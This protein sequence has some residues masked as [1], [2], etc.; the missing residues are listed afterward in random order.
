MININFRKILKYDPTFAG[1]YSKYDGYQ[2]IG[3]QEIDPEIEKNQE[4]EIQIPENLLFPVFSSSLKRGIQTTQ[5]YFDVNYITALD[6][7]KEVKFDLRNLLTHHEYEKFG[8]NLVRERFI[9]AFINDSL[10][11]K[12]EDIKKRI[13][14]LQNLFSNLVE[15]N[16]LVIS[17]SFFMKIFDTYILNKNIFEKPDLLRSIFDYREKTFDFGE[18]FNFRVDNSVV[19]KSNL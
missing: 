16:Y 15:G 14:F 19:N 9:E 5:R 18:G 12:R 8:S 3:T 7:L 13:L 1:T 10:L 17:H 4:N 11:E 6:E 2:I